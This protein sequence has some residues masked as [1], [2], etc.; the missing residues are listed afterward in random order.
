MPCQRGTRFSRAAAAPSAAAASKKDA[1][2]NPQLA[3][4]QLAV[5][6]GA[7]IEKAGGDAAAVE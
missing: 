7:E 5:A 1:A 3:L 4:Y 6:R 2:V